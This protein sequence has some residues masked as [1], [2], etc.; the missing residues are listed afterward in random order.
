[1]DAESIIF[2]A[3]FWGAVFGA[4]LATGA[5]AWF[6]R[7]PVGAAVCAVLTP[8]FALPL[9]GVYTMALNHWLCGQTAYLGYWA[10]NQDPVCAPGHGFLVY[11]ALLVLLC[12]TVAAPVL[13]YRRKVLTWVSAGHPPPNSLLGS[14]LAPDNLPT[15]DQ[16][17][18]E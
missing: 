6:V 11:G 16:G 5:G 14:F 3:V 8:I 4:P 1:M 17:L 13:V 7:S 18:E 15:S 2:G 12:A 10:R 9:W